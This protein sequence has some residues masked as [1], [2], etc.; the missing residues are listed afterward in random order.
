VEDVSNGSTRTLTADVGL[1]QG[2]SLCDFS[3]VQACW[4][5]LDA[6]GAEPVRRGHGCLTG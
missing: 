1:T 6:G 4:S 5:R 3:G 2:Y